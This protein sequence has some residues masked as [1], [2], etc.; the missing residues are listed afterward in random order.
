ML[1]FLYDVT[2]PSSFVTGPFFH[3]FVI[4]IYFHIATPCSIK[5]DTL[6]PHIAVPSVECRDTYYKLQRQ[7]ENER[8]GERETSE[9]KERERDTKTERK[10]RKSETQNRNRE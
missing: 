5:K 4:A 9:I 3:P 2:K 8:E 7:S 1:G 6:Q 10:G